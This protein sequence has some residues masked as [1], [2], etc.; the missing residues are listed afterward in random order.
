MILLVTITSFQVF[1]QEMM[2]K[3]SINPIYLFAQNITNVE[4]E[5]SLNEGKLGI[6]IYLGWTGYTTREIFGY[7]SYINEQSLSL[8]YYKNSFSS[9]SLWYGGQLSVISLN[10]YDSDDYNERATDIGILGLSG[11]LGYQFIIKS[12]YLDFGASIGYALTN[13]LFGEAYYSDNIKESKLLYGIQI[14]TGIAF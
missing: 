9:S 11:K 13:N 1:S 14:K 6:S 12:F 3:L 10:I 7:E 2:N 4:Y 8:K 5:R